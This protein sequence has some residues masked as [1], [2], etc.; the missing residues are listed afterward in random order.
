MIPKDYDERV[1][2]GVLG[3]II[4]VYLGRPFEGWTNKR[5]EEQLGEVDYY[6]HDKL[7]VPLIV[8]DDDISGT[9]TFIRALEDYN[10][11]PQLTPKQVGQTWLNHLIDSRSVL[12]WGGLGNSTEHKA[13]LRLR[14]GIDAPYSGSIA[15]YGQVVAEQIGSQIFI[16]GWA[17]VSPGDPEQAADF[18]RRAG[19]VSHDGE[20]IFGAQV[21]AA[22]EAQAFVEDGIDKL[23][24]VGVSQI[25]SDIVIYGMIADIREWHQRNTDDWRK[26]FKEIQG[27]CGYDKY[28]GNCHIVPNHGLIVLALLHGD[29]DFQKSLMIVNTA[30]WDTDCNSGNLGCLMGIRI[31]LQGIDAGT[32]WRGPFADICY[33]PTA[34]S[35]GGVNDAVRETERIVRAGRRLNGAEVVKHKEGSRYH[36]SYPGSVQGFRSDNATLSN[37][38]M[39]SGDRSLAISI[40]DAVDDETVTALTSTF[41]DSLDTAKYF[42]RR[43]Y[44]L[45]S[46]PRLSSGQ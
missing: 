10:Y 6:V 34:D 37:V 11:D 22:M 13:Y 25:P 31:G 30:G 32:D 33:V 40:S 38:Q 28:G 39:P 7:G 18:A 44:G 14:Q 9:F 19:S 24:D 1:Y 35:G 15:T 42:E 23:L 41:V 5:I 17:I 12:W 36:F 3:K 26:T 2:A 27:K 46:S 21:L 45:M 4:G 20:A 29:G 8:T 43:G 16:D